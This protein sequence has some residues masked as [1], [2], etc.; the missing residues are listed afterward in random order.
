[1][2]KSGQF[3]LRLS[4]FLQSRTP[5]LV[6]L[7]SLFLFL[8]VDLSTATA[9]EPG[10]SSRPNILFI[11]VDDLGYGDLSSYGAKDLQTP[12]IDQLAAEGMKWTRFYA[13]C[14]VC[15][16]TRAA[17]MTGLFPD[18]A[19]VPGVI[20][21]HSDNS[22]GYLDPNTPTI[23]EDLS[24]AGYQTAL[25]GKWHL[26]LEAPN[27]PNLRGFDHFQG[28]LGDMMD[29]YYE[30]IRHGINYM[31]LNNKTIDPPGHA[32]DL[33]T[34]WA[35]DFILQQGEKQKS[36]G[37]DPFFL[38]LAYNAPHTPIQPPVEWFNKTMA[39]NPDMPQDRARLVA[40]IEHMDDGIGKALKAL[41]QSNL[42]K[43][44]LV[45]FTSDNGGQINVGANNGGL[46]DGKQSMYEGGLRVP[47][48]VRWPGK[49][50]AN[51]VTSSVGI[52]SDWKWTLQSIGSRFCWETLNA[53]AEAMDL[54][55][56]LLEKTEPNL[57]RTLYFCRREGGLRYGG[58]TI[59][60]IIHNDW[61]LLQ[62]S[63]FQ[64][65]ELY[66]IQDDP[67][68]QND[69]SE[70][71]PAKVAELNRMLRFYIQQGGAV[72]WFKITE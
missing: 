30:H 68:E 26:G 67:F 13:N 1:M 65:L 49:I 32:T 6:L 50:R 42:E 15:S 29:D 71:Q 16:P 4:S 55:P 70:S 25:I 3:Y 5:S 7:I 61:K 31:R 22:W 47:C 33:F 40:L 2:T 38:Y 64:D 21:T 34:E 62:N 53:P 39:S 12:N 51:S 8:L 23:A 59:E 41:E 69:L 24:K 44:T 27:L 52:T 57:M 45:V 14:P 19:G 72:P 18:Q 56:A 58:K 28:W 10:D 35:V 63:P 36:G 11:M 66:N 9:S 20:R 46:R 17:L 48:I 54:R 60:A 43:N 37:S